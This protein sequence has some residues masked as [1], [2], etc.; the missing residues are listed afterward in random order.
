MSKSESS[1]SHSDPVTS[2][3]KAGSLTHSV[4]SFLNALVKP[5]APPM[6]DMSQRKFSIDGFESRDPPIRNTKNTSQ[7]EKIQGHPKYIASPS[8]LTSSPKKDIFSPKEQ[9]MFSEEPLSSFTIVRPSIVPQINTSSQSHGDTSTLPIPDKTSKGKGQRKVLRTASIIDNKMPTKER[10]MSDYDNL[11]SELIREKKISEE[12]RVQIEKLESDLEKAR[13]E[14]RESATR[15][16]EEMKAEMKSVRDECKAE[17]KNLTDQLD[18]EK[19]SRE[20]ESNAEIKALADRSESEKKSLGEKF[21][22]DRKSFEE[23]SESKNRS[24]REQSDAE[25]KSARDQLEEY[26]K[27][28]DSLTLRLTERDRIIP[29]TKAVTTVTGDTKDMNTTDRKDMP[30]VQNVTEIPRSDMKERAIAT[31]VPLVGVLNPLAGIQGNHMTGVGVS[32]IPTHQYVSTPPVISPSMM[33]T[34][35][36]INVEISGSREEYNIHHSTKAFPQGIK[37]TLK[38]GGTYTRMSNDDTEDALVYFFLGEGSWG[39]KLNGINTSITMTG[40]EIEN[41]YSDD[42]PRSM[43]LARAA[44][45][46]HLPEDKDIIGD[47]RKYL[48]GRERCV[49]THGRVIGSLETFCYRIGLRVLTGRGCVAVQKILG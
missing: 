31:V 49:N 36:G 39:R 12:K 29:E 44:Y 40:E 45:S 48:P 32:L 43:A 47:A 20:R 42:N 38:H 10:L 13:R 11:R 5:R 35:N 18:V 33:T 23:K 8:L 6:S 22:A 30:Q 26:K 15:F 41:G 27:Q 19:K 16:Q 37:Y 28:I 4:E 21:E 1:K 14:L 34:L 17:I 3:G 9:D 25:I 46:I 7:K 24:L 2:P